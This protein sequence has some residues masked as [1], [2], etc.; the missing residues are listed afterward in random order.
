MQEAG[1][2]RRRQDGEGGGMRVEGEGKEEGG[3]RMFEKWREFG[4]FQICGCHIGD[5]GWLNKHLCGTGKLRYVVNDMNIG[6]IGP[7]EYFSDVNVSDLSLPN[8]SR[9]FDHFCLMSVCSLCGSVFKA[10]C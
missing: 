1:R 7:I 5:F 6:V 4:L 8:I 9:H 3:G 2:R 10:L